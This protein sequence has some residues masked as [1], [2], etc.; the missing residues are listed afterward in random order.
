MLIKKIINNKW[1][2]KKIRDIYRSRY[3]TSQ[4]SP[5][6]LLCLLTLFT[7]IKFLFNQTI[8]E[9]DTNEIDWIK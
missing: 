7:K 2:W 5:L 1:W 8:I 3:L 4:Y 6:T 9:I